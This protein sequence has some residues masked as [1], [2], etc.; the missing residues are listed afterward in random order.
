MTST[1]SIT[2]IVCSTISSQMTSKIRSTLKV[3]NA[4]TLTFSMFS[5]IPVMFII[6]TH[7]M[8]IPSLRTFITSIKGWLILPS[9]VLKT[10]SIIFM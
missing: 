1:L 5:I 8:T 6:T 10:T 7:D 9:T 4:K 2:V 3:S